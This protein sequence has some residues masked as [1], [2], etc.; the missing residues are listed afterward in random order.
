MYYLLVLGEIY[1]PKDCRYRIV[2][3][4]IWN[5][6]T[7]DS[8][9]YFSELIDAKIYVFAG[10]IEWDLCSY[11]PSLPSVPV[12]RECRLQYMKFLAPQY[13]Y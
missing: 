9:H 10:Y 4:K 12:T 8:A 2:F 11:I 13:K 6:A 7:I 5:R 1:V 3:S